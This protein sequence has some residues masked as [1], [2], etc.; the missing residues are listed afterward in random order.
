MPGDL[1]RDRPSAVVAGPELFAD[2]LAAQS[3]M[4]TRVDWQPPVATNDLAS[5]WRDDVDAANRTALD[6]L[7]N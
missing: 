3:V 1:L 4:V 5:L 2:A 7:L 6:R